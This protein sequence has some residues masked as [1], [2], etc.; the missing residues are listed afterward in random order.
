MWGKEEK[1]PKR[2]VQ[3][4]LV[5]DVLPMCPHCKMD[6]DTI[7]VISKGFIEQTNL[8]MCPHCRALLSVGYNLGT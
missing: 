6:L 5:E 8:Y 7:H 2:K 4:V 3:L 1:K